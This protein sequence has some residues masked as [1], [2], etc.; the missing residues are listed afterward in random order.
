MW[1]SPNQ[2]QAPDS[3]ANKIIDIE[4]A[5]SLNSPSMIKGLT[6][7][8]LI[9]LMKRRQGKRTSKEYASELG[10][11]ASY[12]CEIYL[13]RRNPGDAILAKFGLT[14]RVIYEKAS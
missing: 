6:R 9:G 11:S 1:K 7:D 10:I 2:S 4:F 8:E 13:G 5:N 12:L 14:D 3:E